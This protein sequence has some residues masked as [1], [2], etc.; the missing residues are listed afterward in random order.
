MGEGEEEVENLSN[1]STNV[2]PLPVSEVI[3]QITQSISDEH[4][5]WYILMQNHLARFILIAAKSAL[6]IMTL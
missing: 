1:S 2:I 5:F 3:T 6:P 4:N